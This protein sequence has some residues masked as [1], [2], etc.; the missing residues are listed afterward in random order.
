M[1]EK[2][3]PKVLGLEEEMSGIWKGLEKRKLSWE[4]WMINEDD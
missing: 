4:G 1:T 2:S 3:L